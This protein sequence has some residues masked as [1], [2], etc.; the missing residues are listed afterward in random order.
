M[1]GPPRSSR[2]SLWRPSMPWRSSLRLRSPWGGGLPSCLWPKGS[3]LPK[4]HCPC[5][6]FEC[7]PF[8]RPST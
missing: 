7:S 6:M 8:L 1:A 2:F 5:S 3:F 4:V